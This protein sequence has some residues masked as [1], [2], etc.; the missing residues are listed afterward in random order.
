VRV[1][2]GVGL[3]VKVGVGVSVKVGLGVKVN[4]GIGEEAGDA[5]WQAQTSNTATLVSN[6]V[7]F[8]IA[9]PPFAVAR[10]Q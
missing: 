1:D 4:V 5:I 3:G 6:L 10:S 7:S 9:P 2:V 8:F